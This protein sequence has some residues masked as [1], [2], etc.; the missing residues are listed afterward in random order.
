MEE[1]LKIFHYLLKSSEKKDKKRQKYAKY[2]SS[3]GQKIK[4]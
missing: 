1:I 2:M 3:D 4:N